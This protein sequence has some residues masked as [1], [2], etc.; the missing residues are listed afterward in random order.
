MV[1]VTEASSLEGQLP[2]YLNNF[3]T[4]NFAV[5]LRLEL[6]TPLSGQKLDWLIQSLSWGFMFEMPFRKDTVHFTISSKIN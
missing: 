5:N 2:T 1:S 6:T 4:E 3:T